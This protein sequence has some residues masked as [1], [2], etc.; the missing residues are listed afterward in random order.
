VTSLRKFAKFSKRRR[1][2][3]KR[4]KYSSPKNTALL[5]SLQAPIYETVSFLPRRKITTVCLFVC[6]GFVPPGLITS[7]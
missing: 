7:S 4:E 1:T 5:Y 6:W 2:L 3:P